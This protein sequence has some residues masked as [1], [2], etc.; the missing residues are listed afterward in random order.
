M[1]S[2]CNRCHRKL[3]QPLSVVRGYGDVCWERI[4]ARDLQIHAEEGL[5]YPL[6]TGPGDVILTLRDGKVATNVPH[7]IVRHSPDGFGWGY[8][9][10]GP[11]ELALNILSLFLGRI[12]EPSLYQEF[13]WDIIARIPPQGA[14][15]SEKVI[16][17][18]ITVHQ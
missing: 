8:G 3:T 17:H 10:S 14:R 9:G 16:R 1:S 6:L 4:K 18:W 2:T 15:I 11:T 12:P 7:H 13:K 5:L